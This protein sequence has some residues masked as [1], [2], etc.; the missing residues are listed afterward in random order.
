MR[1]CL[2]C[3]WPILDVDPSD[4]PAVVAELTEEEIVHRVDG[5]IAGWIPVH[6]PE[7]FGPANTMLFENRV[8][9]RFS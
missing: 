3:R 4:A 8:T 5:R 7:Q 9:V 2:G 1:C 6:E